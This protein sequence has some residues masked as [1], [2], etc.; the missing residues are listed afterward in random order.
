MI[1][2]FQDLSDSVRHSPTPSQNVLPLLHCTDDED[3]IK[4]EPRNHIKTNWTL[5]YYPY[6]F[7]TWHKTV[8]SVPVFNLKEKNMPRSTK[9]ALL[10]VI[11]HKLKQIN[12]YIDLKAIWFCEPPTVQSHFTTESWIV[13]I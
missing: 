8:G 6:L 5:H 13:N 4:R 2:C 10:F 12:I 1:S 9:K 11:Y 3:D 7:Y